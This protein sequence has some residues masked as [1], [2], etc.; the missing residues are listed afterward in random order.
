MADRRHWR[1]VASAGDYWVRFVGRSATNM[2]WVD[3]RTAVIGS[4]TLDTCR[5]T[6]ARPAS[7]AR[8][9]YA[10]E[11]RY[12]GGK[13]ASLVAL[14]APEMSRLEGGGKRNL[15]HHGADKIPLHDN[16]AIRHTNVDPV[17]AGPIPVLKSNLI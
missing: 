1:D 12:E 15:C 5:S 10:V 6:D 8:R 7:P 16:L 11:E 2:N 4:F 17:P 14:S 13:K 9:L 3:R